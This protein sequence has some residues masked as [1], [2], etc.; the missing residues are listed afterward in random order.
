MKN[1][2]E[3][4]VNNGVKIVKAAIKQNLSLAEASRQFGFKRNYVSDITIRLN[5]NFIKENVSRANYSKFTSLMTRREKIKKLSKKLDI[6][7]KV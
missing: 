3:K 1:S 6:L 7:K 2:T 5:G 4:S